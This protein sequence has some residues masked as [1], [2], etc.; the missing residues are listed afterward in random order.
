M[1]ILG[2]SLK[3]RNFFMPEG[4]RP[5]QDLVRKALFDSIGQD[6]KDLKF[7]DLFAGSGSVGLE[8]ISRG[9][10]E[11]FFVER[12]KKFSQLIEDNLRLLDIKSYDNPTMA[13]RVL[14]E[15]AFKSIKNLEKQ[16]QEFDIIFIDPPYDRELSK[17]TLKTL[18]EHDILHK[19]CLVI[20]QH[21]K[22]E[23]LPEQAGRFFRIREKNYGS[24][25]LTY[26]SDV[27]T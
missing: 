1:K 6:L 25:V 23:I 24:T 3:G 17:K 14:G 21:D 27:P 4:I 8:A 7:L 20:I 26:Y 5:T 15:D 12:E 19:N 18:E 2:G 10:K 13:Y 11:V 9:A 16:N 22:H